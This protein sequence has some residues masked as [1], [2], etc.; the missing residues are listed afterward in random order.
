MHP[1]VF[2]LLGI[3]IRFYG[4]ALSTAFV[5]GTWLTSR[6]AERRGIPPDAVGRAAVWGVVA[7][8]V[9]ARLLFILVNWQ[10]YFWACY[11]YTTFNYLFDPLVPLAGPR[12][13]LALAIW[14]G[15]LVWYG[16]VLG[17]GAAL[18][19]Y[20]RRHGL[21]LLD[22]LDVF[23]P[24]VALGHGI[25]RL[26]CFMAGCCWGKPSHLPWAV[27]FPEGS[28]AWRQ[29]VRSGVLDPLADA[30][31]P[32]H[33]TQLYEAFGEFTLFAW[34]LWA[35]WRGRRPSGVVFFRYLA[36]YGLLRFVVEI[37]RAD[38][39]RGALFHWGPG[40]LVRALGLP[41]GS[42]VLLSTSQAL[43]LVAVALSVWGGW[44]LGNVRQ[45]NEKR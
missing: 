2:E 8:L 31:L 1:V 22:T 3:S 15:G 20:V 43:G 18:L 39:E 21:P 41:E 42:W 4:L 17:A 33:P 32:V 9:A 10:T 28:F 30:S 27:R 35:V 6:L 13:D 14:R 11:D 29:Q 16:G 44:W 45:A 36:L 24:G 19:V 23:T 5:L 26:G 34:L 40:W 7:G 38:R 37:F 12:C 25:G